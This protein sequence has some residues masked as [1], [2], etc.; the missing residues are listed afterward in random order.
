MNKSIK[1]FFYFL[2]TLTTTTVLLDYKA[3]LSFEFTGNV[4]SFKFAKI[5]VPNLEQLSSI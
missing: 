3:N 2:S 5:S 4:N 1:Y